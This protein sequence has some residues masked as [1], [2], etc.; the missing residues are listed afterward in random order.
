[1]LTYIKPNWDKDE[2]FFV[3]TWWDNSSRVWITQLKDSNLNQVGEV[4]QTANKP[5]AKLAH[6]RLIDQVT[7]G[8]IPFIEQHFIK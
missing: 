1:M 4:E 3:E 5:S 6:K 8:Y 2:A 7:A